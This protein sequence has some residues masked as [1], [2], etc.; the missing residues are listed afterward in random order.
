MSSTICDEFINLIS[1]EAL[2]QIITEIKDA[3]YYSVSVDSTPDI[4]HTDQLTLIFRYVLSDGPIERFV[5]FIPIHGHSGESLAKTL[6]SFLQEHN[7]PIKDC[8]GQSYDNASNMS[9][10]YI[11]M[12][13]VIRKESHL[14]EY[15]P[16][17]AHSLNLVRQSAVKCCTEAVSFFDFVQKLYV[18]F[19]ASTHRWN[20]LMDHFKP[21]GIPTLKKLSDTRWS[22]HHDAVDALRIGYKVIKSVL[23][24]MSEDYVQ[25]PETRMEADGLATRM[26]Y[27]G[28]GIM[29]QLWST[30]LNRFNATSKC[31]QSAQMDLN[32]VAQIE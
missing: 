5:K 28:K 24:D 3:K 30:I 19:S 7:I 27:L 2:Q 9:G 11:G 15:I 14:A 21:L 17:S 23:M 1:Q 32:T 25:K 20:L 10:K 12:Q 8:R 4:S 31:L 26:N 16:C 6:L 22:A 18:F 29:V 13:A